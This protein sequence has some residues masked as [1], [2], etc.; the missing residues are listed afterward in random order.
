MIMS[1]VVDGK[2]PTYPNSKVPKPPEGFAWEDI[3]YVI[4]GFGWKALFTDKDGY[5]ITGPPGA[6]G[7]AVAAATAAVTATD[8]P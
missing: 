2:A 3:S 4:G 8:R 7:A 1:K 6:T 5:I